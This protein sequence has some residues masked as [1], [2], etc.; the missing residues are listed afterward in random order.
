M[1]E[2][3]SPEAA[4]GQVDRRGQP[5]RRVQPHRR[6]DDR[7]RR[8]PA[9]PAP[10]RDLRPRQLLRP[11]DACSRSGGR[12][13]SSPPARG[14]GCITSGPVPPDPTEMLHIRL[15]SV[16]KALREAQ[17]ADPRRHAAGAAGQR[18]PPR[19]AAGRRRRARD[20]GRHAEARTFQAA[21]D[22][23]ALVDS[24]CSGM[25]L[26]KAGADDLDVGPYYRYEATGETA[27]RVGP[28]RRRRACACRGMALRPSGRRRRSRARPPRRWSRRSSAR[29]A[30]RQPLRVPGRGAGHGA[31]GH[32]RRAAPGVRARG[33]GRSRCCSCSRS[34]AW[35]ACC[36]RSRRRCRGR[37]CWRTPPSRSRW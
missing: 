37:A 17:G 27:E 16:I 14:C 1:I 19:R 20:D 31:D 21:L 33:D 11:L 22:R 12:P 25:I 15:P 34:R 26:N 30:A 24:G 10:A 13:S 36:S 28:T 32:P 2:I 29:A 35:S 6:R 9:P 5:R 8:R 4:P 18:R 23:L 7:A 3:T